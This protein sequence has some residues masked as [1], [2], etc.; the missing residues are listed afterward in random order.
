MSIIQHPELLPVF[1]H[2][3]KNAGTYVLSWI[4]A[5]CSQYHLFKNSD[6]VNQHSL[7]KIRR[8]L[9]TLEDGAQLSCFYYTPT[10]I[11]SSNSNFH[12]IS[13]NDG[14][15]DQV[16]LEVF[17]DCIESKDVEIFCIAVE[18]VLIGWRSARSAI[19]LLL[20]ASLRK[21]L[22][23][24][25]VLRDPYERAQSIFNYLHDKNSSHEPT[26][27]AIE[28]HNFIDY[29]HSLQL[30]DSWFL[31]SV[32][33]IPESTI[34]EPYHLTLAHER[35]LKNFYISDITQVDSL[36]NKVFNDAYG[37]S[38]L[39]IEDQFLKNN[40]YKNETSYTFKIEFKDLNKVTQQ[41]FLDH[42]YWDRKIWERYCKKCIS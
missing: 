33:N 21:S 31:R 11:N 34:I 30:E 22:L 38:Q 20:Q 25:V 39:D 6:S 40:I 35:W 24:F 18:P 16:D 19:N 36:I 12:I 29:I 5:L 26:H 3:P 9:L 2:I 17:I 41:K 13:T 8:V 7:H 27:N 28:S 37:I 32:I 10:N 15:S 4:K 14:H 1:Y 42:T 23:D